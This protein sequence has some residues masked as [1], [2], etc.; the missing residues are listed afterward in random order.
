DAALLCVHYGLLAGRVGELHHVST[1]L[2]PE[3]EAARQIGV[4]DVE[5]A[6]AELELTRL[7]VDEHLVTQR[8]GPGQARIGKTGRAV[9]LDPRQ[10]LVARENRGDEASPK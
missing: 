2:R 5:T 7:D 3:I 10:S 4:Q 9:H 8:H 6:G 1:L